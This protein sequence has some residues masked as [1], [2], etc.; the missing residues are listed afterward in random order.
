MTGTAWE[1]GGTAG[2]DGADV[3]E[4]K[5][6]TPGDGATFD[7]KIVNNS[8]VNIQYRV[9]F[10]VSG[11]LAD[12]LE[13]DVIGARKYAWEM[14]ALSNETKEKTVSVSVTLPEDVGADYQSENAN[15]KFVVEALQGNAATSKYASS[16][17]EAQELLDNARDGDTIVL[18]AA[19]A[20]YGK[21]YFR[22][23]KNSEILSEY[24]NNHYKRSLKNVTITAEN[25]AT[26]DG[27]E[28][29]VGH[30]YG[31][32]TN[33]VTG[34]TI[35]DTRNSYHAHW[36]IED[37]TIKG[38]N[39]TGGVNIGADQSEM[40]D[41]DGL[42]ITDCHIVGSGITDTGTFNRLFRY[43]GGNTLAK[44]IVIENC[45]AK[46]VYQ[47]VYTYGYR[48]ITVRNCTFDNL[49][50]NAVAIQST[51]YN[52]QPVNQGEIVIADN[53]MSGIH[54][55]AI[56]IGEAFDKG[57]I[58]ITGNHIDE[59]SGDTDGEL[60]KTNSDCAGLEVIFA[61]NY[62]GGKTFAEAVKGFNDTVKEFTMLSTA[63]E[64]ADFAAAVNGGNSY[65]GETVILGANIDL[66]GVVWTPIGNSVEHAF[67]G[68][69]NGRKFVISNLNVNKPDDSMVGLFGYMNGTARI[70]NVNIHNAKVVGKKQVAALI[71]DAYTGT[72]SNCHITGK[73]EIDGNYQVGGISGYGY[74]SFDNCSVMADPGSYVTGTYLEADV[75][76]DAV[77]GLVGYMAEDKDTFSDLK[78]SGLTVTGTRKVG[79][80]IG[81][82][83]TYERTL[84]NVSVEN[85]TVKIVAPADYI[86]GNAGKL[87][88]GGVFGEATSGTLVTV[89]GSVKNVT[90]IGVAEATTKVVAGGTRSSNLV[91]DITGVTVEN[92]TTTVA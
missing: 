59:N 11:K 15:I 42:T 34:E 25:G 54:D 12:V 61:N 17:E 65:A 38:L 51:T 91:I 10:S 88:V 43:G 20:A 92:S 70:E 75:E 80:L 32:G 72:V 49:G 52:G 3:L 4:L 66:A 30:I 53:K 83:G 89:K 87:F 84:D 55:R 44:N 18:K 41:L 28:L 7:I 47:G 71:G 78:V 16:T 62:W 58:T 22:Q 2:F 57:S 21:L 74:A 8:N 56:R 48:D 64:L 40:L 77:G 13:T 23:T 33:P 45:T 39:M 82:I 76:G 9:M 26:V 35:V 79:G 86:S 90:V 50:H 36:S 85:T 19:R 73:V 60:C 1:N 81:Q 14:W 31:S 68:T 29:L 5:Q 46:D 67:K 37:L 6:I 63:D 27:I 24:G 69:F